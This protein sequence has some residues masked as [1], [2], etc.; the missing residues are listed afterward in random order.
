MVKPL[1][2]AAERGGRDRPTLLMVGSGDPMDAALKVALD[3]RGLSVEAATLAEL[4]PAIRT[5]APDVLLLVGDAAADGGLLAL[6]L[7]G[8]APGTASVPVVLLAKD[9]RLES[10]MHAFRHGAVAVVPR[11]ASA[12]AVARRVADLERELSAHA[13][14]Q[15][16]GEIGEATFEELVELVKK[17]LRSG[18]LSVHARGREGAATRVVLGAGRPVAEAVQEFVARLRPHVT[19]AEPMQYQ[20]HTSTGG[21]VG[22]LDLGGTKSTELIALPTLRALVVDDDPARADTLAHELR[23]RGALVFVTDTKGSGLERASGLDPQIAIMDRAGLQGAGFEVVRRIRGHMRLRWA[24]LLVA[25]WEELWSS[26]TAMPDMHQLA[27]RILGM[28][29]AER[30]LLERAARQEAFDTRLEATGPARMV[31]VLVSSGATLHATIRNPKARVELDLAEGLVVGATSHVEGGKVLAGTKALASLLALA[32]GRVHIERRAHPAVANVMSPVDEALSSATAE[33]DA[34]RGFVSFA[35]DEPTSDAHTITQNLETRA[36]A[37]ESLLA[38]EPPAA[39]KLVVPPPPFPRPVVGGPV[40]KGERSLSSREI[41]H[42]KTLSMGTPA[43][44]PPPTKQTLAMG[45]GALRPFPPRAAS[46]TPAEPKPAL[47]PPRRPPEPSLPS[48]PPSDP[49]GESSD[50][51][52]AIMRYDDMDLDAPPDVESPPATAPSGPATVVPPASESA[53]LVARTRLTDS[54][55]D[56]VAAARPSLDSSESLDSGDLASLAVG[57]PSAA[58]AADAAGPPPIEIG[59]LPPPPLELGPPLPALAPLPPPPPATTSV[60]GSQLS[61]DAP[62]ARRG[63]VARALAKLLV[64]G[65]ATVLVSVIALIAYR[66][67]GMR[68]PHVDRVLVLLGAPEESVAPPPAPPAPPVAPPPVDTVA[69]PVDAPPVDAPP[70]DAPPVGPPPVD[71]PVAAP[72]VAAPPVVAPVDAPPVDAPPVV[73]PADAPPVDVPPVVPSSAEPA[74]PPAAGEAAALLRSAQAAGNSP[75]AEVYY[76]RALEADPREH[77]AMVGLA[78]LLMA[79]GEHA[80]AVT[81]MRS[82][83]SRRPRR[84]QYL[85]WYGDALQ[86]AG[87]AAGARTEWQR[88][89]ELEPNNRQAQS[90]LGQ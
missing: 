33:R 48:S 2:R 31:R 17:E 89:L 51:A 62:A 36:R 7:L 13:D 88:A 38:D 85:L 27:S 42:R 41:L 32:S 72:P 46:A 84:A 47:P 15:P 14:E 10:R 20:F 18:I 68:Q 4:E 45:S 11:G 19:A 78:R 80:E 69:P 24:S 83:V 81:L 12:D 40:A 58:H 35:E 6:T 75:Q 44:G 54:G 9:E 49:P 65:S 26:T 30:D 1:D 29:D 67:S 55:E 79:R 39:S 86:G 70:V 64:V 71:A 52:T 21:P 66:Y 82:A 28:L 16:S 8:D 37:G 63:S 90:R 3:R 87:D 60:P 59:S 76:R 25:P 53:E 34:L 22:V 61:T 50:E 56:T 43:V 77:H 74:E 73:A 5:T 23:E 57:P